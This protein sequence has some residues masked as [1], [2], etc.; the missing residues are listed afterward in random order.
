MGHFGGDVFAEP[1]LIM[2][3]M[4]EIIGDE[5]PVS[6]EIEP[7]QDA[8]IDAIEEHSVIIADEQNN[9]DHDEQHG[10]PRKTRLVDIMGLQSFYLLHDKLL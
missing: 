8:A 5:E 7:D 3:P 2:V 9:I 10:Y 4:P 6:N 1:P